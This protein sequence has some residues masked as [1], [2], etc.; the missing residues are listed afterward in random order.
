M[1]VNQIGRVSVVNKEFLE[2]AVAVLIIISDDVDNA[3]PKLIAPLK[4]RYNPATTKIQISTLIF[5]FLHD[6]RRK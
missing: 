1:D 6:A 3:Y 5:S 4:L 2:S